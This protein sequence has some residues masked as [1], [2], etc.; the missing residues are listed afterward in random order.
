MKEFMPPTKNVRRRSTI[1]VQYPSAINGQQGPDYPLSQVYQ[2]P[3]PVIGSQVRNEKTQG[4]QVQPIQKGKEKKTYPRS[5]PRKIPAG[6]GCFV[7]QSTGETIL[8][9]SLR[10]IIYFFKL[11]C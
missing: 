10:V 6:Y 8:N 3:T 2:R 5:K 11:I 1:Q 9:V 4:Y 7:N